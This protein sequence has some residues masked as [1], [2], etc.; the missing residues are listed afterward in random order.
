MIETI[1]FDM[2]GVLCDFD[3]QSQLYDIWK[4]EHKPDWKKVAQLCPDF[5][6]KMPPIFNGLNLLKAV[7]TLNPNTISKRKSF[8]LSVFQMVNLVNVFG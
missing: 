7:N 8:P 6:A 5:F 3:Y 1:Y 4:P 2:D